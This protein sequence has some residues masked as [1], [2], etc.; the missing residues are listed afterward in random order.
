MMGNAA[1]QCMIASSL[2][3]I[4][5]AELIAAESG[6]FEVEG[7]SLKIRISDRYELLWIS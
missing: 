4:V 6:F 2:F 3:L 5:S 1:F 7:V